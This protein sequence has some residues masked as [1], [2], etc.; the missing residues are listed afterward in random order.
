[1][2]IHLISG[3]NRKLLFTAG[4]KC[5]ITYMS[6]SG[7]ITYIAVLVNGVCRIV[8]GVCS[9]VLKEKETSLTTDWY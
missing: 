1:M 8:N 2:G 3:W 4:S 9:L 7:K 5:F 6:N